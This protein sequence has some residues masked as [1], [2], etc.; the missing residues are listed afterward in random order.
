MDAILNHKAG[1]EDNFYKLLGCDELSSTEQINAEYKVLARSLHP[2]KNPNNPKAAEEFAALQR[3][4][5]VLTDEKK[6]S[7]YDY[8][9]R[10][11]MAIAYSTW[12]SMK[13][14]MHTS[15]HWAVRAKKE[16]MIEDNPDNRVDPSSESEMTTQEQCWGSTASS[17]DIINKDWQTSTSDFGW[18]RAPAD[19]TLRRFRNYQI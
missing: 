2:D 6:R 14:S 5:D 10:S 9:S 7:E 12:M 19:N 1:D 11:G 17:S 4:R 15:L 18:S 13:E 8:W 3:A 16:P